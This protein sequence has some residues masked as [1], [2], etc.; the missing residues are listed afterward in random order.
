VLVLSILIMLALAVAVASFF[1][2]TAQWLLFASAAL[3]LLA[4]YLSRRASRS[5]LEA[6]GPDSTPSRPVRKRLA[7]TIND[8]IIESGRHRNRP[9]TGSDHDPVDARPATDSGRLAS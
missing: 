4:F 3:V 5:I 8:E 9:E 2:A 6:T 7:V 1:I